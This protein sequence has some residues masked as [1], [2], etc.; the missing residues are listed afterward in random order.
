MPAQGH[1]TVGGTHIG[2]GRATE[3]KDW[4]AAWQTW[5]APQKAARD[6]ARLVRLKA[7]WDARREAVRPFRSDAAIDMVAPAHTSS[8]NRAF[9]DAGLERRSASS[10]IPGRAF[11][12]GLLRSLANATSAHA[13]HVSVTPQG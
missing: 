11:P 8:T 7:R 10:V 5:W 12:H 6:G 3:A 4:Y 13:P 9:C 1:T 2:V